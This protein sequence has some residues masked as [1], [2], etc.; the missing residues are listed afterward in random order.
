MQR[1]SSA[2]SAGPAAPLGTADRTVNPK[3]SPRSWGRRF[4]LSRL[5]G[6]IPDLNAH[7]LLLIEAFLDLLL[8]VGLKRE[9][10]CSGLQSGFSHRTV[11]TRTCCCQELL[12][13]G[14]TCTKRKPRAA[15]LRLAG[16]TALQHLRSPHCSLCTLRQEH[17]KPAGACLELVVEF[18]SDEVAVQIPCNQRSA[19]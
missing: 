8:P 1:S 6:G 11:S 10:F 3:V 17:A 13:S 12:S 16:S 18:A 5:F 9:W 4:Q 2:A 14:G 7:R 15:P 19:D